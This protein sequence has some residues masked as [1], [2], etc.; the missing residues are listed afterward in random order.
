M[1]RYYYDKKDV[2]EDYL[3]LSIAKLR[4]WGYLTLISSVAALW[5][6]LGAI[7]IVKAVSAFRLVP[8]PTIC[9]FGC[10]TPTLTVIQARKRALI[11]KCRLL[12][13]LAT[14]AVN[15]TGLYALWIRAACTAVSEWGGSTVAV[16]LAVGIATTLAIPAV[17]RVGCLG[18]TLLRCWL[19]IKR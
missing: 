6:G 14:S 15:G 16:G 12:P 10:G 19:T 18:A 5:V 3:R 17:M 2:T 7:L 11:I 4:E 9:I 13:H 1:G 8:T